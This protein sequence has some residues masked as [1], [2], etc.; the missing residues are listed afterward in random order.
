MLGGYDQARF[1]PTNSTFHMPATIGQTLLSLTVES[2]TVHGEGGGPSWSPTVTEQ[3]ATTQFSAVID[4]TLPFI[5]LPEEVC[6]NFI[7]RLGLTHDETTDLYI[8]NATQRATN[9]QL[10]ESISFTLIDD[11]QDGSALTITLPYD[12]FDLQATLPLFRNSTPYFPIRRALS[13]GNNVLGRAFLQEAYV[14]A[15]YERHTFT[16]AQAQ[17]PNPAAQNVTPIYNTTYSPSSSSSSNSSSGLSGGAIGGIVVGIVA[18]LVIAGGLIWWFFMGKKKKKEKLK[19]KEAEPGP[20]TDL[21]DNRGPVRDDRRGTISTVETIN[22]EKTAAPSEL[23]AIPSM[24]RPPHSRHVS[25]L[26]SDSEVSR[27]REHG[28]AHSA[29][30]ELEDMSDATQWARNEIRMNQ[31]RPTPVHQPLSHD[32]PSPTS[33]HSRTASPLPPPSPSPISHTLSRDS[34]SQEPPHVIESEDQTCGTAK[35][36]SENSNESCS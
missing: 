5:Y 35:G 15:D 20:Y 30:F 21:G 23:G 7:E 4:S 17:F 22:S 34:A 18:A 25:E 8:L 1:E 36:E 9:R 26:S 24:R 31:D 33:P 19:E 11:A 14:V 16:V 27:K 12:A 29:I 2:I 3:G 6:N 32:G 28:G 13:N 10:I